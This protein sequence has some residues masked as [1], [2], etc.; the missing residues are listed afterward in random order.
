[1][2]DKFT[3]KSQEA[4]I[5]AQ[6]TAQDNGQQ[7][8][9]ALHILAALLSQN[10]GLVKPILENLG[11]NLKLVEKR[12]FE[13][14]NRLPKT[15]ITSNVGTVQGTAEAAMILERAKK[16]ADKIGDE[17]ISTEHLFLALIGI[18]SKAQEILIS[19]GVAYEEVLKILAKL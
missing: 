5:N 4:I 16:E 8:I 2:F 11:V 18:K 13:M 17:Y 9:E 12:V 3:H 7:Q 14:I 19:S 6:M 15:P 1:M 10:E